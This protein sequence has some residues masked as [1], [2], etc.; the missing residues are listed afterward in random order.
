MISDNGRHIQGDVLKVLDEFKIQHHKSSPYRPQTNGAVEAA[1]KNVITIIKKMT[2]T[3]K[4]WH[5]KL[6]YALWGYR[7]MA[8]TSTDE[9]PF[10]LVYG[11]DVV[12]PIEIKLP[13]LRVLLES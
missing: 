1:N 6:P 11:M 7:T 3:Y 10:S 4:D 12:Q 9:T 13:T 8:R 2:C 5:E